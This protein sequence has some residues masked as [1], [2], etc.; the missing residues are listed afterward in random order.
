M[1]NTPS[2]NAMTKLAAVAVRKIRRP[3]ADVTTF[4]KILLTG[5]RTD[6]SSIL[7]P[8]LLI[9][10]DALLPKALPL[11]LHSQYS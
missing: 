5:D 10:L 6:L 9:F 11:G 1:P 3:I 7:N 4:L 8:L 2:Q